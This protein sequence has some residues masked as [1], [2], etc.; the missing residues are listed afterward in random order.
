MPAAS[1]SVAFPSP[2]LF[3]PFIS[4]LFLALPRLAAQ[5]PR[6]LTTVAEVRALTLEEADR[7]LPVRL[8]GVVTYAEAWVGLMYVQDET[9]GT[10]VP[11]NWR[12]ADGSPLARARRQGAWVE[13][14][15]VTSRGKFI[16][17]PEAPA[18][19]HVVVRLLGERPLPAPAHP[20]RGGLPSHHLHN[21]WTEV[22]AYVVSGSAGG[23]RLTLMATIGGQPLR[24]RVP[25]RLPA[26]PPD[27]VGSDVR[28][29]GVYTA[30]FNAEREMTGGN[31]FVQT[32]AQIEVLDAGLARAFAQEP[33]AI[34]E[35]MRFSPA[36]TQRVRV[37]G[38]VTWSERGRG[39]F[40]SDGQDATWVGAIDGPLPVPGAA[41][42][43]AGFS[44]RDGGR[45][46][47]RDAVVRLAP[48]AAAAVPVPEALAAAAARERKS[49]GKLVRIEA[50]VTDRLTLPHVR[51]LALEAGGVSFQARLTESDAT[52]PL[53]EPGSWV[54]VTGVCEMLPGR[55]DGLFQI[56]L[57]SHDDI[58]VLATPPWWTPER[59]AWLA[60]GLAALVLAALAWVATLHRRVAAQTAQ[61]ARQIEQQRITEER[62]RIGR[63]LHDT[64]E[65]NLT[66]VAIQLEAAGGQVEADVR[67]VQAIRTATAMLHHS[68]EEV[69]RSVWGLRSPVLERQGLAAAL[70][71][72]AVTLTTE[73]TEVIFT[74]DVGTGERLP[75]QTEFQLF[76]IAQEALTNALKHAQ[77]TRVE[78]RLGRTGGEIDL[79]VRDNGHGF[80]PA[81]PARDGRM[82]F[83][84]LGL[85]ERVAR[86]AGKLDLESA[87]GSGTCLRVRLPVP[88]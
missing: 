79:V 43:V 46:V 32:L 41:V 53:P 34:R 36:G 28:V 26:V 85:G 48:T 80:D 66:G 25:V 49:H 11:A 83:G 75:P 58:A 1:R 57:R 86:V 6:P 69:R 73:K 74:D 31:F 27:L 14:E 12:M 42:D 78:L 38:T 88:A 59:I 24:L 56:L 62:L 67:T 9:G 35:I 63:E 45:P 7:A 44:E 3:R 8:R 4:V 70:R 47:L 65:Q 21:H 17:H 50:R 51:A 33:R 2:A 84:L 64:L 54:A 77:A 30:D 72:L 61:I 76:R 19:G 60:G 82:H 15:A 5:E 87:P 39:F 16:P 10:Y 18:G 40:L 23:P 71:E 13:L 22:D 52:R 20:L 68:R 55:E 37:R 81:T 29:R